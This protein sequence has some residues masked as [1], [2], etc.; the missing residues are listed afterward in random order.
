MQN[1]NLTKSHKKTLIIGLIVILVASSIS[2]G[3]VKRHTVKKLFSSSSA[4]APTTDENGNTGPKINDVNYGPSSSIDNEQINQQKE[5]TN[6]PTPVTSDQINA[7]ITN[8]RIVNNLAQV[9]VLVSGT[10]TGYCDIVLSKAGATSVSKTVN[11]ATI[12][13]IVTCE[14]FDIPV[15]Q[16]TTGTWKVLVTLRTSMSQSKPTEST[17]K[18]D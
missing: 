14:N 9:S 8:T 2:F 16:L 3:Y 15:S 18:V 10:A 17:L 7:T 4:T 6:T 11:M 12:E 13:S 1:S 5:H